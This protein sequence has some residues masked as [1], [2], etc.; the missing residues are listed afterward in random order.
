MPSGGQPTASATGNSV[1]VSW[2][3]A[4][5]PDGQSVFGYVIHRFN[6]ATG[7]QATVG[8]TCSGTVTSTACTEQS[9]PAGT[10]TYTDSPVQDNWS[11]SQS[12]ASAG[13]IVP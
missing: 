1:T 5:F 10:W 4:Y 8:A 13:V 3:T 7:A 9:V 11:G 2:P 6:A 12:P